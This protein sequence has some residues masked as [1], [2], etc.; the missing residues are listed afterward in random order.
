L[1]IKET[2]SREFRQWKVDSLAVRD[3]LQVSAHYRPYTSRHPAPRLGGVPAVARVLDLLDVA[4][5]ARLQAGLPVEG[6]FAN[7]TQSV[8]RKPW[9]HMKTLTAHTELYDFSREVMVSPIE[10]LA[11]H[12]FPAKEMLEQLLSE[13]SCKTIQSFAGNSMFLP[14]IG[15]VMLAYF[16]N[17]HGTWWRPLPEVAAS[18]SSAPKRQRV[19]SA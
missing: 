10:E 1:F 18:S 13:Y 3:N 4:E 14:C 17:S 15:S 11:L 12:G 2:K 16:L 7:I 8:S 6:Y 5:S 9:G 19:G